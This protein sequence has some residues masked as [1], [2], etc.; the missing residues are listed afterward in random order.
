MENYEGV[1]RFGSAELAI[2]VELLCVRKEV[3]PAFSVP[4]A[5]NALY[6]YVIWV[7]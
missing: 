5:G 6:T 4:A 7:A 1:V 3:R 2:D